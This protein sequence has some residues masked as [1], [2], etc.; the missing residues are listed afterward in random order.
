MRL[1]AETVNV[2]EPLPFHLCVCAYVEDYLY[3]VIT[4]LYREVVALQRYL[5]RCSAVLTGLYREAATVQRY[6]ERCSALLTN[7]LQTSE[8][9]SRK[10]LALNLNYGWGTCTGFTKLQNYCYSKQKYLSGMRVCSFVIWQTLHGCA[11]NI[12]I[13]CA[14]VRRE[15]SEC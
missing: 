13:E 1:P 2:H 10:H 15:Q 11:L 14:L 12:A 7:D 4:G 6:L 9:I 8:A 3:C 5:D